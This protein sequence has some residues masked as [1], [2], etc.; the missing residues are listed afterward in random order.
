M[1]DLREHPV[2]A[3]FWD[4]EDNFAILN[5]KDAKRNGIFGHAY[6]LQQHSYR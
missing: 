1:S 6:H 3:T 5:F 4:R 2:S